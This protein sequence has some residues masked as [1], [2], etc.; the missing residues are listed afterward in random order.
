M[1]EREDGQNLSASQRGGVGASRPRRGPG[2]YPWGNEIDHSYANFVGA[3][4]F[5]TGMRVGTFDGTKRGDLQTHN[6]ASPY[7]AFDMAGN[8][9]EWCQDWYAR[10][11]Y[12]GSPR[13]DP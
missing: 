8:V 3:S 2:R 9:M 1:V 4:A 12:S 13:K 6:G 11:Y 7:G 10:D 5:D